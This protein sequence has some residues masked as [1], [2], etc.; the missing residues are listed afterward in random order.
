[1]CSS[2]TLRH[3]RPRWI[4]AFEAPSAAT[5]RWGSA[6]AAARCD[7]ESEVRLGPLEAVDSFVGTGFRGPSSWSENAHPTLNGGVP[8]KRPC[9]S[10]RSTLRR[11]QLENSST[12][13]SPRRR[14]GERR[15]NQQ[16]CQ[17]QQDAEVP[18]GRSITAIIV[19]PRGEEEI[20]IRL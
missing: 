10:R 20:L 5:E 7:E 9:R 2:C 13:S 18:F 6:T 14:K 1:M 17:P 12:K 16:K 4:R 3:A 19:R 8:A 15:W 11:E